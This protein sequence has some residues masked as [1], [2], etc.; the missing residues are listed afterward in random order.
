MV[1]NTEMRKGQKVS[2]EVR[3]KMSDAKKKLIANGWKPLISPG[4]RGKTHSN[5]TKRKMSENNGSRRLDVRKKISRSNTGKV[6][7]DQHREN[8]R[9]ALVETKK[10]K[11]NR[12][13]R[14]NGGGYH[15]CRMACFIR[16]N[17]ICQVCG[18]R[19]PEIME[20]DHIKPKSKY[21]ELLNSLENLMTLCPNCHRRKTKRDMKQINGIY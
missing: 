11:G 14:W 2:L 1:L 6:F 4:M 5:E 18:F 3:K 21:P 16:D 17:Y 19:D 9:R 8:I 13:P 20:M 7:S 10:N 12:N 15:F